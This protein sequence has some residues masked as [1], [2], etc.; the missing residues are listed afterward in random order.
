[1]RRITTFIWTEWSLMVVIL[2]LHKDWKYEKTS[3]LA[4]SQKVEKSLPKSNSDKH[5][6]PS[7]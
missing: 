7:C 2:A 4:H 5:S 1:M 6:K 3:G